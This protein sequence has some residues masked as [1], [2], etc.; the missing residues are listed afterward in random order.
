MRPKKFDV[1][2]LQTCCLCEMDIEDF[3]ESMHHHPNCICQVC[4]KW[5]ELVHNI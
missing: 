2:F 3:L 5:D 4:L 1:E